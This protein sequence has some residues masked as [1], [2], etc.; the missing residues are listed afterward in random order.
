MGRRRGAKG[1]N[2]GGKAKDLPDYYAKSDSDVAYARKAHERAKHQGLRQ[3]LTRLV[4]V[5]A[6]V[7]AWHFWG[8]TAVRMIRGEGRQ[9]VDEIRGV[10]RNLQ[11]GRDRRSGVG[12]DENP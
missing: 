12:L 8:P 9:T 6:L 1:A 2:P 4:V 7:A 5:L 10:G 3:W 11:E